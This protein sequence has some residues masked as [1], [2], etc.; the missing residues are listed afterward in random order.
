[1]LRLNNIKKDYYVGDMEI[2]ALK[3]ISVAFR[4]NEFV[5]ILGPSGCGKTTMLNIIGGL[6]KYTDGDLFIAGRSTKEFNDRDWD[7]YRN[8]R[9]GFIFQSYNLIP[10]QTVLGNVELAL[11]IAGIS[12][13]ERRE[14]A[15]K[16]LDRVG[17]AGQYRKKPNQLSGGQCQRVAI[18]RA[19][20]NEPEILLA[21]E[22][23]GALDTETSIQIMDL[24]KEI[25]KEKLVIM[26]THNPDLADKYSTRIVRCLDGLIVDDTNPY[27]VE[28][29]QKE[30]QELEKEN[31]EQLA[32]DE[33][34]KKAKPKEKAKMSFK[35]AFSLSARNLWSKFKRTLLVGIAGSIGII[36]VSAV[37][38]VSTGVHDYIDG[39]Q[40][41][42]LSGNPITITKTGYDLSAMTSATSNL[43]KA[44]ALEQGDWVNVQSII[45][46]LV[47]NEAA[48]KSLVYTNEINED[49]INYIMSMPKEYYNS[50]ALNY[51]IDLTSSLYTDFTTGLDGAPVKRVSLSAINQTY[52]QAIKH[53]DES[54]VQ[55]AD[56]VTSLTSPFAQCVP[57]N[58]YIL[59][60]YDLLYGTMPKNENEC[61]IVINED[62][63]VTDLILAQLGF[64]NEKE[65]YNMIYAAFEDPNYANCGYENIH[66]PFEEIVGKKFTWYDNDTIFKPTTALESVAA[67]LEDLTEQYAQALKDD[68][69]TK[70]E[71]LM[72]QIQLSAAKL[73]GLSSGGSFD[74]SYM[75]GPS[76]EGGVDL[77]VSGI[78]KAKEDISYGCLGAGILYSEDFARHTIKKNQTS[79]IVT[80]IS[81]L[82]EVMN[83]FYGGYGDYASATIQYDLEYYWE[84]YTKANA[85]IE[86][87]TDTS[88]VYVGQSNVMSAIM[89]A[90]GLSSSSAAPSVTL[91]SAGGISLPEIISIYPVNF[92]QKDLVTEYLD[93][94]NKLDEDTGISLTFNT[95]DEDY[96]NITGTK[97]L[98]ASERLEIKY[99]D[100]IGLIISIINTMVDI[101]TIALIIFTALSLVVSCVM[102]AIITYVSVMER[103]KEIGVIRALGGRKKDVSHLFNAETFII[104]LGSGLIGV[105]FTYFLQ[106]IGNI[107]VNAASNGTVAKIA[108]LK[109]STA[110]IMIAVS[111]LLTV[112][113][114]LIPSR[115]AAKKDPVV[116][117][118]TE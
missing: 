18:A 86:S 64:I 45:S 56:A 5:S 69:Q 54:Y 82:A 10:H 47:N 2:H 96:K 21:D 80:Y 9:I 98:E 72:T 81:T 115:S 17:L 40:D 101:I 60:Q 90:Y 118:R 27:S 39:M 15:K 104:G 3:G 99:A 84:K 92:D 83:Q 55:Y 52:S 109:I 59:S 110:L 63:T 88:K 113:S 25:A 44:K 33:P 66:I 11:T 46:Y 117:L 4:K 94:W 22:P 49:Y 103:I 91:R 48:L 6:D 43:Q 78:V 42:M 65:F 87:G 71:E 24:I 100:T 111:I 76:W 28:E 79:Q 31:N 85:E 30:I 13:E 7:V 8:H 112:I 74:Y 12:K 108:H 1:M 53:L 41:D 37:L 36:G 102:I 97:T 67:E 106:F 16:A 19:L 107:I 70:M 51:G 105:L 75:E 26:V 34:K 73:Y 93:N 62:N 14:R 32:V 61:I 29:E 38:A 95:F 35:T 68:N 114:G 58:D 57:N 89:S 20:V 23:T 116:A 50:I 77:H